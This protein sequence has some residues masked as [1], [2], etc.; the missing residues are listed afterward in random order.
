MRKRHRKAA[1]IQI[2]KKKEIEKIPQVKSGPQLWIL[3]FLNLD[4]NFLKR[5]T[6]RPRFISVPGSAS[7][8]QEL[9]P[10]FAK[11]LKNM[12]WNA[13]SSD[14]IKR[15]AGECRLIRRVDQ[16][17]SRTYYVEGSKDTELNKIG[18]IP[19]RMGFPSGEDGG[20]DG[21]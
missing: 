3:L 14:T 19:V 20:R 9:Y 12:R 6:A 4:Y 10:A 8:V 2:K 13:H 17:W 1:R 15:T 7:E 16:N 5:G 18:R 21:E 11:S